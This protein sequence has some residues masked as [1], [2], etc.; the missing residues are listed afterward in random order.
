MNCWQRYAKAGVVWIVF[1]ACFAAVVVDGGEAWTYANQDSWADQWPTCGVLGQQAPF[2]VRTDKAD[3]KAPAGGWP[4]ESV[5]S[6]VHSLGPLVWNS[7]WPMANVSLAAGGG[8]WTVTLTP[9]YTK[10]TRISFFGIDYYLQGV[11]YHSPS[12]MWV[13][14][15]GFDMEAQF[16]HRSKDGRTLLLSVLLQVGLVEPNKFM[17]QF[18]DDIPA[19]G[20]A[21][22]HK[23]IYGPYSDAVSDALPEDRTF[24]AFN[25]TNTE[26]P[27]T[28]AIWVVLKQPVMISYS[29]R[30]RFRQ[31]LNET[32]AGS[33]RFDDSTPKGV[34]M[35]W[36]INGDVRIGMNNRK[37]QNYAIEA[38]LVE[39][40]AKLQ[41][42]PAPSAEESHVW[43]WLIAFVLALVLVGGVCITVALMCMGSPTGE[44]R[45]KRAEQSRSKAS[46]LHTEA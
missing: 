25:A 32:Q 9:D 35:P 29:Q 45:K 42:T 22:V 44:T 33:L 17:S 37:I 5:A 6:G 46:L 8:T 18:F 19:V 27:C 39:M 14:G 11:H 40:S 26:P 21:P 3:P 20:A 7:T 34:I 41:S 43:V 4:L 23:Y 2:D 24:F 38:A 36:A 10:T 12:E 15:Q 28:L 1:A 31:V 30:D 13:D 16:L